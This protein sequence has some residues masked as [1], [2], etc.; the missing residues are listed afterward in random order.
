[1]A[2]YDDIVGLRTVRRF[3]KRPVS[4][5]DLASVLEA[6]R[7]TGSAKNLQLWSFIVVDDPEQKARLVE[8][9]SFMT[10]VINAPMAIALVRME[11]G[12]DFDTGR[13][14]QNLMLAADAIGLGSC[15][16]TLHDDAAARAVL[17]LP[18]S[19]YCRYAVALGYENKQAEKEARREQRSRIPVGRKPLDELVHRN[20]WNG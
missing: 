19:A 18:D 8:T 12:Y 4:D 15:P 11:G 14:A 5:K 2:T 9:G 20:H 10:P 1:M 16:V 13:V 7:W 6:A 17:Q 3:Q